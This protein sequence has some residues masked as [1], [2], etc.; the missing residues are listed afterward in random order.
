MKIHHA[1]TIIFSLLL[2]SFVEVR[3]GGGGGVIK[4]L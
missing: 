1:L 4:T 2:F 3:E